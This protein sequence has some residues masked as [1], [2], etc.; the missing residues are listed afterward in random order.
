[1]YVW[2][3]KKTCIVANKTANK[4]FQKKY[5]IAISQQIITNASRTYYK[6]CSIVFDLF[7]NDHYK[8]LVATINFHFS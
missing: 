2:F 8:N 4:T 3:S 6:I 7:Y 1:M 5:D